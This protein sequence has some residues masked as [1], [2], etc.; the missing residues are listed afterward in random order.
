[1]KTTDSALYSAVCLEIPVQSQRMN[2]LNAA[3]SCTYKNQEYHKRLFKQFSDASFLVVALTDAKEIMERPTL[4]SVSIVDTPVDP[5]CNTSD[6]R[7][8]AIE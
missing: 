5:N 6:G 8:P 1:M 2:A 3:L 4:V 7:Y